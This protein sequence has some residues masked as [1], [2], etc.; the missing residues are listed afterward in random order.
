M[1]N[2]GCDTIR[3]RLLFVLVLFLLLPVKVKAVYEVTDSRCT[4]NLIVSL[5]DKAN[6]VYYKITKRVLKNDVMYDLQML[7]MDNDMYIVDSSNNKAYEYNS[8]IENIKPGTTMNIYIYASSNNYCNGYK[9]NTLVIKIPYYNKYSTYKICNGYEDYILCKGNVNINISESEFN[10][11]MEAYIESLSDNSE[12][13]EEE[14][15]TSVE[16]NRF[17][18]VNFIVKYNLYISGF[19]V[20]L[21][22]GYIIVVIRIINKKR[23]IL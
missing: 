15:N 13:P 10:K 9:L 4:T 18:L 7:N 8:K 12:K 3:T 22:I 2:K 19:G 17:D 6:D 5:K 20:L 21:L 23:G 11:Q 16:S 1:N 14:N